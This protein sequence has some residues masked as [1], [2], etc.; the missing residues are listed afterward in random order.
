MISSLRGNYMV[1]NL[2]ITRFWQDIE[3]FQMEIECKTEFITVR[4][5][6]YTTDDLI[7]DL[8]NKIEMFLSGNV[9]SA[10]WQNGTR[11]DITTPCITFQLFHKDELGHILIEVF[12]EIDDGGTLN[13]HNCCFYV[14][15]EVGLLYQFKENLLK[16]KTPQL[17]IQISLNNTED[18]D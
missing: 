9:N 8:Y 17:G 1:D 11:G 12:M 16:L 3:F 7:D 10:C 4:G 13:T 6:V 2:I 14:N 5:K 15:T 18:V